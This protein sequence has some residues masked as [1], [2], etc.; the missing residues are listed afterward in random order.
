[1]V[2]LT[3][4]AHKAGTSHYKREMARSNAARRTDNEQSARGETGSQLSLQC[5]RKP[6]RSC[7][8]GVLLIAT[9][10][11]AIPARAQSVLP[12][13]FA[14]WTQSAKEPFA[15]TAASASASP[16][17]PSQ[18][19]VV[20]SEYGFS[21]GERATYRRGADKLD[22]AV[23][24]MKDPSGAYGEYSY[25]RMQEMTRSDLA[26][27][28][29]MSRD[30]ALV[31]DGNLILDIQGHDLQKLDADLK[32]LVKIVAPRAERGILPTL[33]NDLPAKDFVERTDHYVLGPAALNELFP[34]SLGNQLGFS[35]GAEAEVAHYRLERR[36]ATLLIVDYPTPQTAAKKLKELQQQFDINS[37]LQN[38]SAPLYAKRSLTLVAFVAGAKSQAEA[39]ALL[40]QVQSR[41]EITWN[42]PT[43]SLTEPSIGTMI[44]GTIIGTGII[45]LFALVSGLAFGGV[46]LVVK[47]ALPDKVF[48]R[49]DELQI[50]QLGLS[51]KPIKAEDFYG[52]GSRP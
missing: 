36:D 3:A 42:E 27:H 14:G 46:R 23:Y 28:S 7:A 49:S 47:R 50:L 32:S 19:T 51:S 39:D 20:A 30:R 21:S 34:V 45:C 31:L 37:S 33:V 35:Q 17:N 10:L 13:S 41:T 52:F 8:L 48:D 9:L 2:D 26:E 29:S 4:N 16:G 38:S 11:S 18:A 15:P 40:T 25:L 1:M 43:F 24:R 22:V 5:S 12:L 44:V 6:F